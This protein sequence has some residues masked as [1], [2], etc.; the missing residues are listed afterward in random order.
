MFIQRSFQILH[1]LVLHFLKT[2]RNRYVPVLNFEISTRTRYVFVPCTWVREC[3]IYGFRLRTPMY[4]P[5]PLAH[6]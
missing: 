1:V 2:I 6:T 5:Y 4:G 3:K